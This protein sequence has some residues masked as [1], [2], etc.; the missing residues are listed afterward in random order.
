M[1]L[2]NLIHMASCATEAS[3]NKADMSAKKKKKK[4]T[5]QVYFV[6][7]LPLEHTSM[8]QQRKSSCLHHNTV[9]WTIT[10]WY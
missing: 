2:W 6:L 8:I 1:V 9:K 7:E 3:D 5:I 10:G 4:N